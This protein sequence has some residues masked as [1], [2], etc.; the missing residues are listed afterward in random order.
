MYSILLGYRQI[1]F[2]DSGWGWWVRRE[3]GALYRYLDRMVPTIN[4]HVNQTLQRLLQFLHIHG[5][6]AWQNEQATYISMCQKSSDGYM[7][8]RFFLLLIYRGG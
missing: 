4:A 5:L 8:L 3:N 2:G 1:S 7:K 6:L